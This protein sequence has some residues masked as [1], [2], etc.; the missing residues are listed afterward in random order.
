MS[1]ITDV[2]GPAKSCGAVAAVQS[3]DFAVGEDHEQAQEMWTA[4][5]RR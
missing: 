5:R 3:L 4:G 1:A 2:R